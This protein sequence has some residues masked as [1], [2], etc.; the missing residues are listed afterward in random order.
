[1]RSDLPF[2]RMLGDIAAARQHVANRSSVIGRNYGSVL[3]GGAGRRD[4]M[5]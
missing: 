5:L 4:L 1:L 2:A 3:L